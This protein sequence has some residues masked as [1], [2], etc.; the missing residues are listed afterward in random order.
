[1]FI[2]PT[3]FRHVDGKAIAINIKLILTLEEE[4]SWNL[5][6]SATIIIFVPVRENAMSDSYLWSMIVGIN[7]RRI[8]NHMMI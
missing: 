3:C 1:M 8:D 6:K 2:M 5:T 4:R 7:V